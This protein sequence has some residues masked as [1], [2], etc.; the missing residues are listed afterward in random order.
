M[1]YIYIYIYI[2][3]GGALSV[4]VIIQGNAHSDQAVS[5]SHYAD[6]QRKNMHPNILPPAI[7]K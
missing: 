7:G 1:I 4:M 3:I 2:Y 6:T 5:I